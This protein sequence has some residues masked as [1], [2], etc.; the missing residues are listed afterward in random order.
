[1]VELVRQKIHVYGRKNAREHAREVRGAV[2]L[3]IFQPHGTQRTAKI[4]IITLK[5][6]MDMGQHSSPICSRVTTLH[7]TRCLRKWLRNSPI[8]SLRNHFLRQLV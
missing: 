8:S 2:L 1:M 3:I 7:H 6:K 4:I 5:K